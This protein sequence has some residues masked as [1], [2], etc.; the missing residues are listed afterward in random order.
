MAPRSVTKFKVKTKPTGS[1]RASGFEDVSPWK[2]PVVPSPTG[3]GLSGIGMDS[4]Q[5]LFS[6][7]GLGAGGSGGDGGGAGAGRAAQLAWDKKKYYLDARRKSAEDAAARQQ[8][9]DN[10]GRRQQGMADYTKSIQDMIAGGPASYGAQEESLIGKLG[11]IYGQAQTDIGTANSGL[12]SLLSGLTNPFAGYQAQAAPTFDTT[13]LEELLRT[14]AQET[15][16]LQRLVAATQGANQSQATAF[17]NLMNT[18][19]NV[20]AGGIEGQKAAGAMGGQAALGQAALNKAGLTSQLRGQQTDKLDKLKQM[21]RD[22]A[23][24]SAGL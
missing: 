24:Q 2:E 11:D 14:Q 15:D 9:Q 22:A 19:G 18:L 23:L 7:L 21:L 3:G 12:Q 20:Y 6:S 1:A 16:P 10:L 5:S 17:Q 13:N 4:L 8:E